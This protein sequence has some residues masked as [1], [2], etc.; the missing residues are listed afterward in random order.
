M[1]EMRNYY[2]EEAKKKAYL[3][4]KP[5]TNNINPKMKRCKR[6]RNYESY[7]FLAL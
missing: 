4:N 6:K 5:L 2:G 3:M 1:R 7:N